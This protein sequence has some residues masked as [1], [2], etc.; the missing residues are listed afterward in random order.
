MW[1]TDVFVLSMVMFPALPDKAMTS[2][3]VGA[4]VGVGVGAA[5]GA[6]VGAA[7]GAGVGAVVVVVVDVVVV[8]PPGS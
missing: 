4:A 6:G 7:V 5:V 3:T 1:Y 8:V 2:R